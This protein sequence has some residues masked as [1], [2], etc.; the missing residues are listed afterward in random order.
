MPITRSFRETVIEKAK[1]DKE[2]RRLMLVNGFVYLMLGHNDEDVF[3]GR[4][5]I[6]DYINATLGFQKLAEKTGL[7]AK[8]LMQMFSNKGNPSQHNLNL[9]F[10]ILF[11]QEKLNAEE[12]IH[13]TMAVA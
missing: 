9:V 12:I 3:I 8:S 1:A 4:S 13:K 10:R 2:F 11:K 7:H 5:G 6:R